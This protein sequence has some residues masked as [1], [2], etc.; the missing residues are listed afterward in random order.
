[1]SAVEQTSAQ[2]AERLLGAA[3]GA[4]DIL[5]VHLGDR[6]GWYRALA[7]DGP[8]D[9]V[10]LTRRAGGDP[11]YAREWLEQ[12]AATGML[13]VDDGGFR[14][15][16]GAAEVLTDPN[17]LDYLAP[18]ARM[19][20]GAAVQ[21]PALVRAY[22]DGGGVG[23]SEYGADM[24]ESQSDMNRPWFEHRL[25]AALAG[26]EDVHAL[27]SRPGARAADIG[28]GGGWSSIALARAYPELTIDGYDIDPP[29]VAMARDNARD[30]GGRVRFEHA[31][32]AK[33]LPESTYDAAFAFECLHDMPHP[34][35]VLTA[36]RRSLR[37]GGAVIIMD[38]A[39]APEFTAPA[40][41]IDRLMYGFSL[42]I[43]LPDGK[44]HPGSAGTGTVMRQATLT[45]YAEKAGFAGVEVLPI[46]EFG[47]WRFYRLTA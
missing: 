41:D 39:V 26:V 12:Q 40:S 37:P 2:F 17:S 3:L 11:R 1:M 21:L 22:R 7:E 15:P 25:A 14:L 31:D 20:A 10:E 28:S 46:E 18:L 6:L 16:A 24:R 38:E 43:C 9:A 19:F 35:E 45:E 30:L 13:V 23:W 27:L 44:A 29:S 36:M 8:A 47:F 34:V 5:A 32:A 33:D 42:L 4:V